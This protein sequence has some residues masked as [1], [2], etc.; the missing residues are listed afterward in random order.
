MIT[1]PFAGL[2]TNAS[3]PDSPE[4]KLLVPWLTAK[5]FLPLTGS[6]GRWFKDGFG[7]SPGA[8]P[9]FS[10][11]MAGASSRNMQ[12]R[13]S[14]GRGDLP[15]PPAAK[16][17]YALTRRAGRSDSDH[18]CDLLLSPLSMERWRVDP[19]R[20][21]RFMG[22]LYQQLVVF[23]SP[24]V[25]TAATS[26]LA[27]ET[28]ELVEVLLRL[29]HFQVRL[30]SRSPELAYTV[31]R[32]LHHRL[33]GASKARVSFGL[34]IGGFGSATPLASPCAPYV[35]ESIGSLN[36]LQDHGF[37]SFCLLGDVKMGGTSNLRTTLGRIRADRCE[38]VWSCAG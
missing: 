5:P 4:A 31:A 32:G 28:V 33:P 18:R 7:V 8:D 24:S 38:E 26:E 25:D 6:P 14:L 37:R 3:R 23:S 16:L 35:T 11:T 22:E 20:A 29:S 19:G 1:D 34:A 13:V 15:L 2:D 36:W 9:V 27:A 30:L 10:L 21:A 12:P 17:A